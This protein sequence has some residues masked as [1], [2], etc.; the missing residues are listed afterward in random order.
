MEFKLSIS[1]VIIGAL[2][3]AWYNKARYLRAISLPVLLLVLVW[4]GSS[5]L[6]SSLGPAAAWL[7]LPFYGLAFALFAVT[8]HRLIL[9]PDQPVAPWRISLGRRELLFF[10]WVIAI[11]II[12]KG[13]EFLFLFAGMNSITNLSQSSASSVGMDNFY[14]ISLLLAIPSL[15]LLS[16]LCLLFPAIA[17]DR[18]VGIKWAWSSTKGNG[19]RI[20]VVVVFCPWLFS[21]VIWLVSRENAT[22]IEEVALSLISYIGLAIEIFILSLTYQEIELNRNRDS[23]HLPS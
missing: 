9:L 4:A 23:N 7:M 12:V 5:A 13:T 20:F 21:I 15:Y 10:V 2:Y 22:V 17:V 1:R 6:V 19:W 14:W 3:L 18:Q 11:G 8:C 16:R